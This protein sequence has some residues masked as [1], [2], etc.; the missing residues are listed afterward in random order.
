MSEIRGGVPDEYSDTETVNA[1]LAATVG[2]IVESAVIEAFE[3][4]TTADGQ[5]PEDEWIGHLDRLTIR[6][7]DGHELVLY[8]R[9]VERY[10]SWLQAEHPA[11]G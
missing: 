8:T 9:D 4:Q 5:A 1:L 2:R 11:D 6:F 10:G 7:T 3:G